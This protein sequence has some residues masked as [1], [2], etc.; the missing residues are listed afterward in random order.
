MSDVSLL[1][2][3]NRLRILHLCQRFYRCAA[4]ALRLE[5]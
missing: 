2:K 1:N 5:G 3:R 4:L